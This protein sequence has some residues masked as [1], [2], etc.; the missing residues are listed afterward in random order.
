MFG[1]VS[2]RSF[3]PKSSKG[4]RRARGAQYILKHF[5]NERAIK[6]LGDGTPDGE[7]VS[8]VSASLFKESVQVKGAVE[9]LRWDL[10]VGSTER[11]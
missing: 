3:G 10:E 8:V 2:R 1:G 11:W 4:L 7:E 6:Y 5:W 9:F